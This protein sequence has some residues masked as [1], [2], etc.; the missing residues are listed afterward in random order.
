MPSGTVLTP[1][2]NFVYNSQMRNSNYGYGWQLNGLS[3]ISYDEET[4]FM[5]GLLVLLIYQMVDFFR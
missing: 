4:Y 3:E 1:E 2:L 5:M